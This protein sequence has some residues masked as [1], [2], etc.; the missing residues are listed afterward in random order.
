[1]QANSS[2]SGV[3]IMITGLIAAFDPAACGAAAVTLQSIAGLPCI[4]GD[5]VIVR[6]TTHIADLGWLPGSCTVAGT[7]L[8]PVVNP[9]AAPIDPAAGA[10]GYCIIRTTP[11][12]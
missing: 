8:V 5:L 7:A 9:T 2:P 10:Y 6:P 1:M 3:P 4:P 12:P 11:S